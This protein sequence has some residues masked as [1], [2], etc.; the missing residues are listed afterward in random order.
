MRNTQTAQQQQ[1]KKA[2]YITFKISTKIY[3]ISGNENLIKR[4][5]TFLRIT[6]TNLPFS[7]YVTFFHRC[8]Q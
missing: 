2:T 1:Q 5:I 7:P 8:S 6:K 4:Q 3:E